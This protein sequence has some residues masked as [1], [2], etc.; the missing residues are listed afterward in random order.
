MGA[1]AAGRRSSSRSSS[2]ARRRRGRR[3]GEP[4]LIDETDPIHG[5]LDRYGRRAGRDRRQRIHP[6][7]RVCEPPGTA[8]GLAGGPTGGERRGEGA[9]ECIA[10]PR[11]QTRGKR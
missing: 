7:C 10:D 8:D 2:R 1:V 3:G 5:L 4:A 9:A 11:D 6:R